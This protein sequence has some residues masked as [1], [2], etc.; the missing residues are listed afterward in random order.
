[1][2]TYIMRNALAEPELIKKLRTR[3]RA[4]TI[5]T[6]EYGPV[7]D[8]LDEAQYRIVSIT[9]DSVRICLI[10][11]AISTRMI[12]GATPST[13]LIKDFP[14]SRI[15]IPEMRPAPRPPARKHKVTSA[16]MISE[17][18]PMKEELMKYFL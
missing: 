8:I 17:R 2:R 13:P 6:A 7:C 4:Y 1:M 16:S 11:A 9:S 15:F 18:K 3:T 12:P 5:R 14:T 10:P